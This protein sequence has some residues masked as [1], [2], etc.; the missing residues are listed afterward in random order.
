MSV[1]ISAPTAYHGIKATVSGIAGLVQS[2]SFPQSAA[3]AIALDSNGN[4]ANYEVFDFKIDM[5]IQSTFPTGTI[6]TKIGDIITVTGAKVD[7]NNGA[8]IV[9]SI[10]EDE[11]NTD[12]V[13]LTIGAMR[14]LQNAVPAA[15]V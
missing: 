15:S 10:T 7:E 1:P 13:K 12:F 8:Y 4:T 6:T 3:E 2:V 9:K 11:S 5:S 14:F